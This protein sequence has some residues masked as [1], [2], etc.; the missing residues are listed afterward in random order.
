MSG[1]AKFLNKTKAPRDYDK[2]TSERFRVVRFD[3][4]VLGG[5]PARHVAERQCRVICT[6]QR[7]D[8]AVVMVRGGSR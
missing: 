3:G 1:F 2:A 5:S 4:V 7:A 6:G 8:Y